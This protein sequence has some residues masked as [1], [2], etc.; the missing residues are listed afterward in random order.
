MMI[1]KVKT[2]VQELKTKMFVGV[3]STAIAVTGSAMPALASGSNDTTTNITTGMTGFMNMVTS[4][5]DV[6]LGSASLQIAFA[7]SFAFLAVRLVR[8]LKKG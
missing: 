8:K 4:M 7:A 6:I 1:E 3:G 2:K 5:L